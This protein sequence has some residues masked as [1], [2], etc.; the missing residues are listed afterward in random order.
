MIK[1]SMVWAV[2]GSLLM[3]APGAAWAAPAS[4]MLKPSGIA[5]QEAVM[6]LPRC[7]KQRTTQCRVAQGGTWIVVGVLGMAA[8]AALAAGGGGGK[9]AS[10]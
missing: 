5:S 3:S 4:M 7:T 1:S 10:P 9:S 2:A 6:K 8:L